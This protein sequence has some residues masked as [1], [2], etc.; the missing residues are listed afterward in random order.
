[1]NDLFEIPKTLSPRLLWIAKHGFYTGKLNHTE[2]EAGDVPAKWVATRQDPIFRAISVGY[3]D[4][5][6][7]ALTQLALKL[8]IRLWNET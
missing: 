2:D 5:E 4:T 3:G 1:M 6:D 8:G 7:E